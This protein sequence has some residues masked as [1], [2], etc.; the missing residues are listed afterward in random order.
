MVILPELKVYVHVCGLVLSVLTPYIIC[1]AEVS[2]RQVRCRKQ[3]G[4]CFAMSRSLPQS[5]IVLSLDAEARHSPCGENA[6]DCHITCPR[7]WVPHL[8][9]LVVRCRG[10]A[11]FV[12]TPGVVCSISWSMLP[13]CPCWLVRNA[14]SLG[15]GL[16]V[17]CDV[18]DFC[19][20]IKLDREYIV[21]CSLIQAFLHTELRQ[22]E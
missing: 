20:R 4:T 7:R 11:C 13:C 15:L 9:C 18:S 1:T 3:Q 14:V 5:L 22:R 17:V 10:K 19:I 8:D 21:V 2:R 12:W 16:A 6:T